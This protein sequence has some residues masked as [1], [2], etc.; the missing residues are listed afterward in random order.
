MA[1]EPKSSI[2][3]YCNIVICSEL[4]S[5]MENI[6]AFN[7]QKQSN[8][9]IQILHKISHNRKKIEGRCY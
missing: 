5:L 2:M 4:Q 3:H 6:G 1:E 8:L 9:L 7:G